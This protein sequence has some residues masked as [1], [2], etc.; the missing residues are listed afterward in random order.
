MKSTTYSRL[1]QYLQSELSVPE[2]AIKVAMRHID[3][4]Q[5]MLPIALWHE[6]FVS[7]DQF[8]QIFDWLIA[9]EHSQA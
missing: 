6:G 7:T 3:S 2:A 1:L 8:A 5:A 4:D 9:V